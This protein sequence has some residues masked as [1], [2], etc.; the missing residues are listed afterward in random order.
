MKVEE[1]VRRYLPKGR[2]MQVA[3]LNEDQPWVAT[4]YYVAD[5]DLNL[6]WISTPDRRHSK[7]LENHAKV[8][9]A[10]PLHHGPGQKVVGLQL[11]GH[12]QLVTDPDE[13]ARAMKLYAERYDRSEVWY[14]DFLAGKNPHKL[15]KIK[16]SLFVLFDEETF[17]DDTRREWRP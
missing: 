10:I 9:G 3:T 17:P 11:E 6:Y 7:E 2:M 15:Y 1:L 14:R 16:P 8:A 13:M 12:A 4:L 5:D